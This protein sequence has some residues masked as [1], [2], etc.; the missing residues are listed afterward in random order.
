MNA[1]VI[2]FCSDGIFN[3]AA[4]SIFNIIG[5]HSFV[6]CF[7]RSGV[8]SMVAFRKRNGRTGCVVR[9]SIPLN[10]R[11]QALWCFTSA[12]KAKFFGTEKS[13]LSKNTFCIFHLSHHCFALVLVHYYLCC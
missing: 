6:N 12:G 4:F 1:A 2:S 7:F 8:G 3:P 13:A 5:F 9:K 11:V 10:Q